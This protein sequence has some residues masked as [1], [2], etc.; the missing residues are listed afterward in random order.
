MEV[1][2]FLRKLFV[3][4]RSLVSCD[5]KFWLDFSLKYSPPCGVL[6]FL[7]CYWSPPPPPSKNKKS[8]LQSGTFSL[9]I[10]HNHLF[11]FSFILIFIIILVE[12][13]L[14]V[15]F[16]FLLFCFLAYPLSVYLVVAV[17]FWSASFSL[18]INNLC[19]PVLLPINIAVWVFWWACT[20][21]SVF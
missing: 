2:P 9:C 7:F 4:L 10:N 8:L 15:S 18:E 12:N 17:L 13:M 19:V 3:F 20:W 1:H 6:F 21:H 14:F 11:A 5:I 16:F